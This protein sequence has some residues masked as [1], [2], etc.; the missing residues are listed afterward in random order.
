MKHIATLII[1]IFITK[2][3][4]SQSNTDVIFNEVL[5][6]KQ[7]KIIFNVA[8][9]SYNILGE[10]KDD[11]STFKQGV[12]KVHYNDIDAIFTIVYNEFMPIETFIKVFEK[13]GI[14]Y[15][16][17]NSNQLNSSN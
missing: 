10:F 13:H 12:V 1:L 11:L 17:T 16:V 15:R 3:S 5:P 9:Y 2:I 7:E 6:G 8:N 4:F 14:N